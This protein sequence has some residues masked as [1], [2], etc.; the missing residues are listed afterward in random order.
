MLPPWVFSI[1]TASDAPSHST[2]RRALTSSADYPSLSSRPLS[3]DIKVRDFV[4]SAS[5][6]PV[7]PLHGCKA[8][9]HYVHVDEAQSVPSSVG[10]LSARFA[11]DRIEH[12]GTKRLTLFPI[13]NGTVGT[14]VGTAARPKAHSSMVKKTSTPRAPDADRRAH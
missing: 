6:H 8:G 9:T 14:S 10:H 2:P 5:R 3:G 7:A 1:S 13:V 11:M 12:D 4:T